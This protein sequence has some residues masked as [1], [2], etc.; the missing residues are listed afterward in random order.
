MYLDRLERYLDGGLLGSAET[1]ADKRVDLPELLKSEGFSLADAEGKPTEFWD[2]VSSEGSYLIVAGAGCG[3]TTV[4]TWR[5]VSDRQ[6]YGAGERFFVGTFL[7]SGAVE[8]SDRLKRISGIS[9]SSMSNTV[10]ST[11]H[12]EFLS[13]LNEMGCNIVIS[14][15]ADL[16][17]VLRDVVKE[18]GITRDGEV[19]TDKD[20]TVISNVLSVYRERIDTEGMD[21]TSLRSYGITKSVMKRLCLLHNQRKK[22]LGLVDFCDL[23][24]LLY[25]VLVEVPNPNVIKFV[26]NRYDRFYLDEFQDTSKKQYEILKVYCGKA[27][28]VTA[29]GDDDQ[30]IYTFRGS[31]SSIMLTNFCA[32]FHAGIKSLNTNYRC[33]ESILTP[34]SLSIRN[35]KGRYDKVLRASK[36]GGVLDIKSCSGIPDMMDA[37]CADIASELSQKGS[38][39]VLC[40]TNLDAFLPA[41]VLDRMGID[42]VMGSGKSFNAEGASIAYDVTSLYMQGFMGIDRTISLLS[43]GVVDREELQVFCSRYRMQVKMGEVGTVFDLSPEEYPSCLRGVLSRASSLLRTDGEVA[44]LS[45][46]YSRVA[47]AFEGMQARSINIRGCL[48]FMMTVLN[49]GAGSRGSLKINS[50]VSFRRWLSELTER[51]SA[52]SKDNIGHAH[53]QVSVVTVHEFKGREADAVYLW[54]DSDMEFPYCLSTNR[55]L[56]E[57]RRLQYIACTRARKT[58]KIYYLQ[59]HKSPFL[60]EMCLTETVKGV[61]L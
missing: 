52:R 54:N 44:S 46:L 45:Y 26:Q 6:R 55:N 19:L 39:A 34:A 32:D 37:L 17:K 28:S 36:G 5:I 1:G 61:S 42:F 60:D 11:F 40:R 14:D 51:L 30:C 35:N 49:Y 59:G 16:A 23:Q 8:L 18:L 13:A 12:A 53:S 7:R 58:E 31:D 9:N 20:Y 24:D 15:A 27:K 29:I 2:A 33:P 22:S 57:E 3:K 10:V 48:Y 21:F 43:R 56:E 25:K 47:L 38:I 4:L 41:M 50:I